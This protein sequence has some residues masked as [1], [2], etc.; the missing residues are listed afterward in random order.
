[1]KIIVLIF[2]TRIKKNA[3]HS[4]KENISIR[5]TD[6]INR[7]NGTEGKLNSE[8]SNLKRKENEREKRNRIYIEKKRRL[9]DAKWFPCFQA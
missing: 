2:R 4:F 5:F 7:D 8:I 6:I 1:M 3:I 9:H